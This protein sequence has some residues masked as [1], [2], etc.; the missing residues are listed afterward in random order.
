[1]KTGRELRLGHL[2]Q[3]VF[4]AFGLLACGGSGGG[5]GQTLAAAEADS[6]VSPAGSTRNPIL[7]AAQVPTLID[8]ASRASTFGNHRAEVGR[9]LRG[10][11]LMVRY[12]DGTLRNLTKEAGFGAEGLQGSGA[13]AV[14]EPSVH[15]SGAKALFSMVV[16][17]PASRGQVSDYVWQIYE[18]SGLTQGEK[19]SITK[20]ANQPVGYNNISPIYGTDG[21][22]LFTTDRP[23]N[24]QAHLYPQLDEYESTP[25]VTGVWSLNPTTGDLRILNHAPSGAFSPT[26]DSY[27]RVVFTR[28]DHLQ[29]D[30]QAEGSEEGAYD[31]ADETSGAARLG[32]KNETFPEPRNATSNSGLRSGCPASEQS[33][34]AVADE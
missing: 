18:V 3:S 13:I 30:Q 4:C 11:D 34:H 28:W 25:T 22:V 6:S 26:I 16:G 32:T 7:F 15:W 31:V 10:G 2:L 9:V 21:R 24:G 20:L 1:M 23:R 14:R 12:P 29:R 33:F 17:A 5:G 27:G 8:F 19:A